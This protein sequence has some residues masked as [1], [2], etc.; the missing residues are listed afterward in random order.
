MFISSQIHVAN[1][2]EAIGVLAAH[3]AGVRPEALRRDATKALSPTELSKE[4]VLSR[5]LESQQGLERGIL[6]PAGA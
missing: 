1:Y 6:V 4:Q 2:W 3:K 5:T